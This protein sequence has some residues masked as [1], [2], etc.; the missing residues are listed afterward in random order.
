MST[1]TKVPT[2]SVSVSARVLAR[3]LAASNELPIE[4][5]QRA[6]S[7]IARST[8]ADE[9]QGNDQLV[10]EVARAKDIPLA[11]AAATVARVLDRGADA[12]AHPLAMRAPGTLRALTRRIMA[13]KGVSMPM[14]QCMAEQQLLGVKAAG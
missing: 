2:V 4:V 6:V 13:S 1:T 7:R 9:S 3:N 8:A 10:A 12:P 5:A 11:D 14:A